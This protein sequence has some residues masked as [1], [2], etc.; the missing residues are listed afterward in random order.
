MG[1]HVETRGA[2]PPLLLLHGWAMHGGIF[3]PL[4]PELARRHTVHCVDLPGHGRSRGAGPLD[5]VATAHELIARF[6]GATWLGWSLGGLVAL[7]A[8]LA[9][10]SQVRALVLV[11]SSPRFVAGADWAHGVPQPVFAGF[12]AELARDWRGTV[13]RFLALECAG[14]ERARATLRTLREHVYDH[15]EPD[16]AV[17]ER[18]LALLE[19]SD[20]R[21]ELPQVRCPALWVAG[22]R[23]QLV[24]PAAVHAA[25]A[26]MP[27]GRAVTIA[28]GGH[29][30]FIGHPE[31][32]LAALADWQA[33][34]RAA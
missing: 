8:A 2:G 14:S 13:D 9:A 4:L 30:P 11:A 15:G 33:A 27:R 26:Q 5:P 24:P 31:R 25:A 34:A 3:A 22:S 20:R 21:A 18:G 19:A 6:P 1:L 12:A 29:A 7:E 16:P 17:L 32:V 28:G 23:D 10:P